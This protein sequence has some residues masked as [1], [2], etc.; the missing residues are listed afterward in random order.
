M[1]FY[2]DYRCPHEVLPVRSEGVSRCAATIWYWGEEPVPEWWVEGVHD[3]TLVPLPQAR[4]TEHAW[5]SDE[6]ASGAGSDR[7]LSAVPDA[8]SQ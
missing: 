1:V 5:A 7:V 2:S 6:R 8:I 4:S 3:C